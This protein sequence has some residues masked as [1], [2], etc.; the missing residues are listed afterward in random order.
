MPDKATLI[1]F[2]PLILIMLGVG[3]FE[4]GCFMLPIKWR[5][6]RRWDKFL[7]RQGSH[8]CYSPCAM[9]CC[10][11]CVR[12]EAEKADKLDLYY[13]LWSEGKGLRSIHNEV[14]KWR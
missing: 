10:W 1:V 2:T 3:W 4:F 7:C 5:A 14:R 12:C 13:E 6:N 8:V 9:G 11:E